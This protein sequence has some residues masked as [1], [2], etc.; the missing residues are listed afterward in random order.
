MEPLG[1]AVPSCYLTPDLPGVGGVIK[2]RCEDFVV[3]ELPLYEPSGMGEH[4]YIWLEKTGQPT[5]EVVRA[6]ARCFRVRPGHIGYAGMKDKHAVTRQYLSIAAPDESPL[7]DLTLPGVRILGVSRHRNKLRLGHLK[8]NRFT[9]RIRECC[10][11][12]A[13]RPAEAVLSRLVETGLPN[14]IGAQ[15]FGLS[16]NNH[17]VGRALLMEDW[18]ELCDI[19]LGRADG[20]FASEY[21]ARHTYD[22]G[23]LEQARACWPTSRRAE[24]QVL[25]KLSSGCSHEE[26]VLAIEPTVRRFYVSAFQSAIFN[27]VLEHRMN[28]KTMH[29]LVSGDLAWKHN[30]PGAGAV[31]HVSP[32]DLN[33]PQLTE[34]LT[35]LDIS[36]SGPLWGHRMMQAT[37]EPGRIEQEA[38]DRTGVEFDHFLSA[39]HDVYGTR[40]PLRVQVSEASLSEGADR[41]GS[42]LQ[43]DFVLP[44]GSFATTLLQEVMKGAQDHAG[45]L[46][47]E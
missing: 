2:Q 12:Q 10:V 28:A 9:I 45:N 14:F 26:A 23:D 25:R 13:V 40:R 35:K 34:R 19:L 41:D 31:F 30:P 47:A 32:D 37:E 15:R 24:H 44:K 17:E 33:D 11:E 16:A 18:Q 21:D 42:Y 46:T 22:E 36:P 7:D 6:L 27:Q 20:G 39:A 29:T 38:L 4:L 1:P 43:A 8:G 5:L 3:E